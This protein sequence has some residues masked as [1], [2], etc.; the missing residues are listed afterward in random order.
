MRRIVG[1][2]EKAVLEIAKAAFTI[3]DGQYETFEN[4]ILFGFFC[5]MVLL[6]KIIFGK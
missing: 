5:V 2:E 4:V 6:A 3:F 1:V